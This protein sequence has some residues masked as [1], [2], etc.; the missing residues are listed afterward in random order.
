M[1]ACVLRC[2]KKFK[3]LL[4][5][6]DVLVSRQPSLGE[7][8][9]AE[10]III[11]C[12]QRESF[13][14]EISCLRRGRPIPNN[15]RLIKITPFIDDEGLLRAKGRL[16]NAAIDFSAKHPVVVD[17][18]SRLGQLIAHYHAHLAHGPPDYVYSEIRQR[19][20]LVGGK[21]AVKKFSQP[22]YPAGR[23][24]FAPVLLSCQRCQSVE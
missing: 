4:T 12:V 13:S 7:L 9:H 15:S 14:R 19:Y 6:D 18:K 3:E 2:A 20:W 24:I 5:K 21:S 10:I 1:V 23:K 16:D 11:L 8:Q 17:A 22:V